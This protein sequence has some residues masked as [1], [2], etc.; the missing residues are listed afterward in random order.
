MLRTLRAR[1]SRIVLLGVSE[2][3]DDQQRLQTAAIS[4]IAII[5][6]G[7]TPIWVVTYVAIDRPI[8]AAIPG[9]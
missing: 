6:S 1:L 8:A 3:D 9:S 2:D 4:L 7:V 5:V